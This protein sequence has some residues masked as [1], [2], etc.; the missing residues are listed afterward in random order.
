MTT[1]KDESIIT[2]KFDCF[3]VYSINNNYSFF[4]IEIEDTPIFYE[5]LFNYFFTE[6]KLIK[7]CEHM[8][9]IKFSPSPRQFAILYKHLKTY[10]DDFNLSKELYEIENMLFAILQDEEVLINKEGKNLI[11]NDKIGKMGEYIFFCILSDYFHFDCIIPKVHLQTDY[12]M[13]IYGI[14]TLFYSEREN[15]LLFGESKLT[16][17]IGNG[18]NLIQKSL[19][20]YENQLSDEF[21]LV[22]SNRL[23]KDKLYKFNDIYGDVAEISID[24]NQ[25]IL[26]ANI[27]KIGIPLFIAHGTETDIVNIMEKLE[28]INKPPFFNLDTKYYSI[29]LPI[30]D[31]NKL[32]ATFTK[33]I[34][35]KEEYYKNATY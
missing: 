29:S 35:E 26:N 12:N 16:K 13:N 3:T 10:I 5:K 32:V 21:E 7:Y 31:K 33:M 25:F 30:L 24:I 15:L 20:E 9:N 2:E 27:E 22:L 1:L 18:I 28:K 34:K 6:D 23:Y 17:N 11:R 19:N 8:S 14:D 4:H